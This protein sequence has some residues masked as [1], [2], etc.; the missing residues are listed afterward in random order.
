MIT[1][2]TQA[3]VDEMVATAEAALNFRPNRIHENEH[4]RFEIEDLTPER[5]AEVRPKYLHVTDIAYACAGGN[6]YYVVGVWK[7]GP[8]LQRKI[9]SI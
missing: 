2:Y 9:P 5:A 6:I 4:G 3:E 1:N 8:V 7:A